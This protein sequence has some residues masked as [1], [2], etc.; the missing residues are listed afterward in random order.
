MQMKKTKEKSTVF[1]EYDKL[2]EPTDISKRI[3]NR[4]HQNYHKIWPRNAEKQ[5]VALCVEFPM[6]KTTLS[7][8]L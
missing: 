6:R 8:M 2:Q 5:H 4:I 1:D 7:V 3:S